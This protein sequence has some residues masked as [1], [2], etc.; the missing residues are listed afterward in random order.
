[1][2]ST[3]TDELFD[4]LERA[5]IKRTEVLLKLL[6]LLKQMNFLD[7]RNAPSAKALSVLRGHVK[8]GGDLLSHEIPLDGAELFSQVL[9]SSRIPFYASIAKDPAS[10]LDVTVFLTRDC[11]EKSV[12]R[13]IELYISELSTGLS[14]MTV[15]DFTKKYEGMDTEAREG[16][17]EA[18]LALF[19]FYMAKENAL[20]SVEHDLAGDTY[21][22]HFAKEE[23]GTIDKALRLTA[24]EFSGDAGADFRD[25]V[26]ISIGLRH[27]FEQQ[28]KPENGEVLYV[29]DTQNPGRFV[30]I[31]QN[32]FGMH[33]LR[34]VDEAMPNGETKT[35][36]RDEN[37]QYYPSSE[38]EMLMNL[39]DQLH[40]P[41]LLTQEEMLLIKEVAPNGVAIP[42]SSSP[43]LLK[44]RYA[45]LTEQLSE[46]A[47]TYKQKPI[48]EL[49]RPE[50]KVKNLMHLPSHVIT[51][52]EAMAGSGELKHTAIAA[53]T[54]S[55]EASD[56]PAVE[57][58]IHDMLY[59][60]LEGISLTSARMHYEGRGE[61]D[62]SD[63]GTFYLINTDLKEYVLKLNEEGLFIYNG[64][65]LQT[66]FLRSE[67]GFENNVNEC[68]R[69]FPNVVVLTQDEFTSPDK[70]E[71]IKSRLPANQNMEARANLIKRSEQERAELADG[72]IR[73][74][75]ER[76]AKALEYSQRF[77]KKEY[78]IS[79]GLL[80]LKGKTVTEDRT[81]HMEGASH[82]RETSN[83][84]H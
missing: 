84:E 81:R 60:G 69:R 29:V 26:D 5:R 61:L 30:S 7:E 11:D 62:L 71:I 72:V 38:R 25:R 67:P 56:A 78:H 53:D 16:L 15:T 49:I 28:L 18:E 10:G 54:V 17:N 52:L 6:E 9:R 80:E 36:V 43:E 44:E 64:D 77:V 35:V 47:D 14:E 55:Y 24:Y 82:A 76:Q 74:L 2:S 27:S 12:A 34:Q 58:C 37:S 13:A 83:I 57:K 23:A 40:E 31:D 59:T 33:N 3:A 65:D 20:Y 48:S 68:I 46:R 79:R 8:R 51:R 50:Q 41:V 1:M 19:R 22:V 63:M 4:S 73:T 45:E 39:I 75:T 70:A 66:S 21:T 32:A 42:A